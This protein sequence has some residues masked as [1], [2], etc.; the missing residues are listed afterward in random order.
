MEVSEAVVLMAGAGSRL[1][2]EARNLP[3]PFVPILGR[4]LISYILAALQNAGIK[5]V[6][7]V[8]GF[9]SHF[10]RQEISPLIPRGLELRFLENPEWQKQNGLSVLAAA[11][12][13]RAPFLLA[14][15]DHLFEPSIL[16]LLFARAQARELNLAVDRKLDSI[17]D[18]D[19]GMKVQ[20][21]GDRVVTLGKTLEIYD[22]IDTG[23]FLCPAELF[24]YLQRSRR[25]GDCSLADGVRLMAADGKVRA[26]DIG[27][28]WWQDVDTPEMRAHAETT[29][30]AQQNTH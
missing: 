15:S 30:R 20:T 17:F 4:P 28:A 22:A 9:E 13:V 24:G 12:Q 14:M 10:V 7:A 5:T 11:K 16:D 8:V 23:I 29:L 19:D 18:L 3:K 26:I 21:A 2:S 25:D 27:A 1:R 6:Y